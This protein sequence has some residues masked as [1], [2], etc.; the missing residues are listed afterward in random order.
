MNTETIKEIKSIKPREGKNG[1]V[2]FFTMLMSDWTTVNI[3]K[4]T[5]DAFKVGD[6]IQYTITEVDEYWT[7]KIREVTERDQKNKPTIP[8]KSSDSSNAIAAAV[9]LKASTELVASGKADIKNLIKQADWILLWLKDN[10]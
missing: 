9:A 6:S 10:S 8:T 3:G 1:T 2:H 4:K 7:K 5:A